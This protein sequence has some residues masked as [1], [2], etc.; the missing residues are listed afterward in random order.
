MKKAFA[1]IAALA[2]VG[3]VRCQAQTTN[4]LDQQDITLKGKL[5]PDRTAVTG[6]SLSVNTNNISVLKLEIVE[7]GV[8]NRTQ[9][10]GQVTVVSGVTNVVPLL[11]ETGMVDLTPT[12]TTSDKSLVVF[13]G[14]AGTA[15]N[16]VLFLSVSDKVQ[17]SNTTATVKFQ[18]IWDDG[19]DAVSGTIATVKV[20]K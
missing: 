9:V 8:T 2:V 20:K 13:E 18:G 1:I 7:S 12:T 14:S 11:E 17:G 6:A 4:V 3:I 16:A 19:V 15:T 10:I 5:A